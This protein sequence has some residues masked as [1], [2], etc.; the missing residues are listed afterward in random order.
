MLEYGVVGDLVDEYMCMSDH[1]CLDTMYEFYKVVVQLFG[2]AY[3]REP[4][5]TDTTRLLETN[6]SRGFLGCM[7]A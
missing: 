3:S 6:A 5:A 4:N 1:T 7:E 2:G